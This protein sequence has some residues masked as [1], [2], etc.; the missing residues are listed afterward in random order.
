MPA[1]MR[2]RVK[3]INRLC[4]LLTKQVDRNSRALISLGK[5]GLRGLLNDVILSQGSGLRGEV[6]VSYAAAGIGLVLGDICLV[7]NSTFHSIL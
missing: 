7:A 3:R 1:S 4:C 6:C 5:N 2:K